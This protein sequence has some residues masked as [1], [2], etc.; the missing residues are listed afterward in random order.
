MYKW[1]KCHWVRMGD[2]ELRLNTLLSFQ[3]I[4]PFSR[5]RCILYFPHNFRESS[6]TLWVL[7]ISGQTVLIYGVTGKSVGF[8][9][10]NNL[11]AK[12]R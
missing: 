3:V 6:W 1:F 4:H 11:I 10:V 12:I 7:T 5:K 9:L 8:T 2:L